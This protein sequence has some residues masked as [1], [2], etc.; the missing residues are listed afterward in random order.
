[1]KRKYDNCI[2]FFSVTKFCFRNYINRYMW[3]ICN[4][5]E[6]IA[7]HSAAITQICNSCATYTFVNSAGGAQVQM[8]LNVGLFIEYSS[9]MAIS[10]L[11]VVV[12]Q[13]DHFPIWPIWPWLPILLIWTCPWAGMHIFESGRRIFSFR[14]FMEFSRL[15]VAQR[16]EHWSIYPYGLAHRSEHIYAT[17]GW[18]VS[19]CSCITSWSLAQLTQMDLSMVAH[20]TCWPEFISMD[21]PRLKFYEIAKTQRLCSLPIFPI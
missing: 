18:I 2:F 1:M 11:R 7:P 3:M 10:I 16:F 20:L 17:V 14:N 19:T 15:V 8:S 5:S 4:V 21:I 13:H 6:I 9:S 12:S